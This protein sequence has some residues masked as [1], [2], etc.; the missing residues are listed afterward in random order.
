MSDWDVAAEM[1]NLK[2]AIAALTVGLTRMLAGQ[3]RQTDILKEIFAVS[4]ATY[5]A[6]TAEPSGPSP[7][8]EALHAILAS[9]GRIEDK[10]D[11][12]EQR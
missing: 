11:R 12:L 3:A 5:E 9:L 2:E 1:R 10:L 7:L 6:V 4:N 8:E